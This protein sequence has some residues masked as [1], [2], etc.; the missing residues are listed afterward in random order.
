MQITPKIS[1]LPKVGNQ[2]FCY[3]RERQS[4]FY[5]LWNAQFVCFTSPEAFMINADPNIPTMNARFEEAPAEERTPPPLLEHTLKSTPGSGERQVCA[6]MYIQLTAFLTFL[7]D[8]KHMDPRSRNFCVS[9]TFPPA[10]EARGRFAEQRSLGTS[11]GPEHNVALRK[12]IL[13]ISFSESHPECGFEV[14]WGGLC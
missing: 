8:C 12:Q 4:G 10:N 13:G 3:D 6:Q 1:L 9:S 7:R 14:W 5:C 11:A 2:A